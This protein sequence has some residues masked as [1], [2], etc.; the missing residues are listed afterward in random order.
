MRLIVNGNDLGPVTIARTAGDP[1]GD[2]RV[3]GSFVHQGVAIVDPAVVIE[4][5]LPRIF[6][7]GRDCGMSQVII[8]TDDDREQS[9]T[10]ARA[11]HIED[12]PEALLVAEKRDAAEADRRFLADKQPPPGVSA[13]GWRAALSAIAEEGELS[14]HG[15]AALNRLLVAY[16][17]AR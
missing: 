15:L 5:S 3:L 14:I 16:E 17:R 2:V 12:L 6:I 9:L 4:R 10:A 8:I 11:V 1:E 7:R 13:A